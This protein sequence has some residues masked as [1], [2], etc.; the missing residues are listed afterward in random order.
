MAIQ[1]SGLSKAYP[2]FER[3][4]HRLLQMLA[5]GRRKYY[6]EFWALRGLD[7]TIFRGETVGIIGTNGSGKSTLLQLICG[8]LTPTAGEIAVNGTIAALLELG[9]GFNPE[10]TGRENV[11][12]NSAI[13]GRSDRETERRM[14]EIEAFADIGEFI[15]R[16]VK[17]YSSGMY[18]R[19][20]FS[21]AIHVDPDILVVDEA[22]AVG[23]AAFARKCFARIEAIKTG[24]GTILFVSH[25]ASQVLE[26]CDRAVLLHHGEHLFTGDTKMAVGFYQKLS[27]SPP[28]KAAEVLESIQ[29]AATGAG[30]PADADTVRSIGGGPSPAGPEAAQGATP[31]P[32][33]AE[34]HFDPGLVSQSTVTYAENGARIQDPHIEDGDGHRVNVLVPR[35]TYR[36]VYDVVFTRPCVGVRFYTLV[37]ATTGV[38]LGGGTFPTR[39]GDPGSYDADERVR[40]SFSFQCLLGTGVYFLNCG[41]GETGGTSLHRIIDALMFRVDPGD[42]DFSFGTIDFL[43]LGLVDSNA[44]DDMS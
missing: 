32:P 40:V 14:A 43:F 2:I 1:V 7:L 21:V 23:D 15:E 39:K 10:F 25:N 22:L 26:L 16:P 36:M 44:A 24:G 31:A 8:S 6:R 34:A 3:P 37:R 20:A 17:T 33:Q 30:A 13:L 18:A 35:G 19:L 9:T 27:F 38:E 41:V 4:E 12:M 28:D 5:L 29:A 11:Y 42:D